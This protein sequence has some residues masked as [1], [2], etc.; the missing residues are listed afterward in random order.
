[1]HG[2]LA[3]WGA[4]GM[5]VLAMITYAMPLIAGRKRYDKPGASYV[6]WLSNIGMVGMTRRKFCRL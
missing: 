6:F 5:L 4:Y 2:H 1:M 3:F